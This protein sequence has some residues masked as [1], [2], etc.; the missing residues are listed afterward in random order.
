MREY[1]VRNLAGVVAYIADCNLATVE[2]MCLLKRIPK[3]E[4]KRHISIC[5]KTI[6]WMKEFN[7]VFEKTRAE[8][9]ILGEISVDQW[10]EDL[11]GRFK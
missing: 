7:V 4:L 5:Q 1:E 3:G 6:D 2:R 8:E 9:I 11:K 10:V